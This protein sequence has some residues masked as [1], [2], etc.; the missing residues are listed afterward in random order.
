MTPSQAILLVLVVVLVGAAALGLMGGRALQPVPCTSP[1]QCP[2]SAPYCVGGLCSQC[3]TTAD[4][5]TKKGYSCKLCLG[6]IC[7]YN[8]S[9]PCTP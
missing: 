1:S 9:N 6:T 7:A 3:Q 4:C 5:P 2:P 8:N